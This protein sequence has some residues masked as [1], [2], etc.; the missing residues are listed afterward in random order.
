MYSFIDKL[1]VPHIIAPAVILS[2]FILFY[3]IADAP[4]TPTQQ[5]DKVQR[6]KYYTQCM[7]YAVKLTDA[8]NYVDRSIGDIHG[9]CFEQS[10]TLTIEN[11]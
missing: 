3:F 5:F 8:N 7:D 1:L 4:P 11:K 9:M 2:L 10:K 6:M